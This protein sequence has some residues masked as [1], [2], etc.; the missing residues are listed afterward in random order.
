MRF[1]RKNRDRKGSILTGCLVAVGL[2]VLLL[3]IGGVYAAMNWRSWVA[4]GIEQGM[5]TIID[6]ADLPPTDADAMKA[7]ITTLMQDFQDKKISVDDLGNVFKEVTESP[8]M[9]A[10]SIMLIDKQYIQA[11]ALTD[12]EKAEGSTQ[13][14][15]FIRGLF[16]GDISRTKIDDVTEPIAYTGG[17]GGA[18][19]RI[20]ANNLNIELKLPEDVA[21]DELRAFLANCKA[22][23]DDAGVAPGRYEID[24]AA[25][26]SA[27][28][29][30]ALGRAPA[31]PEGE[32]SEPEPEAEPAPSEDDANDG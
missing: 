3:V 24:M 4:A 16:A 1:Y 18:A 20:N 6:E 12:E 5:T 15:R 27:A 8:L 31:L 29:D 2:V 22:A 13:F 32:T 26:F 30:R 19:M 28:I 14:S 11:S 25:E 23:A 9:P 17:P 10:A 7:E 21:P